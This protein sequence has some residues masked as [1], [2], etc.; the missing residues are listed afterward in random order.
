MGRG[1]TWDIQGCWPWKCIFRSDRSSHYWGR[2]DTE[3]FSLNS[4]PT[5]EFTPD[6]ESHKTGCN[7]THSDNANVNQHFYDISAEILKFKSL[8]QAVLVYYLAG[9]TENDSI[10]IATK[11]HAGESTAISTDC[12]ASSCAK[13]LPLGNWICPRFARDKY[14]PLVNTLPSNSSDKTLV[15][16]KWGTFPDIQVVSLPLFCPARSSLCQLFAVKV[17]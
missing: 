6:D 14:D 17:S 7:A 16:R 13:I 5:F 8:L 10:A 2:S 1:T 3:T 15:P 4:F 12:H 11:K 9:V